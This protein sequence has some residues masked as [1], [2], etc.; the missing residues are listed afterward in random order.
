MLA[1][2]LERNA[3]VGNSALVPRRVRPCGRPHLFAAPAPF[4]GAADD[5][6]HRAPVPGARLRR[7]Y[8]IAFIAASDEEA[9]GLALQ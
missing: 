5:Q 2:L 6:Y 4:G 7:D 9:F 3:Y 8:C 1:C